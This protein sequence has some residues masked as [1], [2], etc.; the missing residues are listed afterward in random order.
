MSY[1]P[2][3]DEA[4]L[5][6]KRHLLQSKQ[7]VPTTLLYHQTHHTHHT[8]HKQH[9]R[10][11]TSNSECPSVKVQWQYCKFI[12]QSFSYLQFYRAPSA[13]EFSRIKTLPSHPMCKKLHSVSLAFEFFPNPSKFSVNFTFVC[14]TVGGKGPVTSSGPTIFID[15][16]MFAVQNMNIHTNR[17]P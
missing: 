1:D 9:Q 17:W 3:L 12:I 10:I 5:M 2:S 13:L 8:N 7:T 16:R 6:C 11:L 4:N 15:S 14:V